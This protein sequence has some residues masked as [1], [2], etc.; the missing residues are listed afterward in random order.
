[1]P[2]LTDPIATLISLTSLIIR[3]FPNWLYAN[4]PVEK[5]PVEKY[6]HINY[7]NYKDLSSSTLAYT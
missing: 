2:V 4:Y 3:Y 7:G 6:T 5:V 1:M